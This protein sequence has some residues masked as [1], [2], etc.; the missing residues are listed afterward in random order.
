MHDSSFGRLLGALVAPGKTFRSIAERPTWLPPLLLLL[1][2]GTAAGYMLQQ[3]VDQEEMVRYQM[4]QFGMEVSEDQMQQAVERAEKQGPVGLIVAPFISAIVFL[5]VALVFW[6]A[7]KLI[8]SE[9]DFRSSLATTV[10]AMLPAAVSLILTILVLLGRSAVT[11]EEM[12]GGGILASSA[13]LFA[14][15]EASRVVKSLLGSLD[16]FSIWTL[17]LL[18]IGYS[19]VAKVSRKSAAITV[20]VVW[21]VYVLGKAGFAAAI[22]RL[23]GGAGA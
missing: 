4:S 8:G 21:L 16:V 19:V 9:M 12:M 7:F 20:V 11:P 13:A 23:A 22:G 18:V 5:I 3:R 1:T 14:P 6:V 2:L 10:H 17:L 15:D